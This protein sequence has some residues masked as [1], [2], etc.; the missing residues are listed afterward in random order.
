MTSI[1][2]DATTSQLIVHL[3]LDGG[4]ARVRLI[5]E[6][7]IGTVHRVERALRRAE[8]SGAARLEIDLSSLD[9]IDSIGL[10]TIL[11]ARERALASGRRLTL[12]PGRYAVQRVF[13]VTAV[14]RFFDFRE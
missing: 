4:N 2:Q 5:G 8:R 10:R 14:G 6:L 11:R 12:R 3:G 1:G 13:D 7:D 9:F